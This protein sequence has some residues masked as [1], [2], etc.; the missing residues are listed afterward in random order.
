MRQKEVKVSKF[1]DDLKKGLEDVIAYKKGKLTLPSK[2]YS[3]DLDAIEALENKLD[4]AAAKKAKEDI[5]KHGSIS[6]KKIK[7]KLKLVV[8][9]K[10]P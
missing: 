3:D 10:N 8:C 5:K 9:F 4:L 2:F 1:F 6:W 7:R